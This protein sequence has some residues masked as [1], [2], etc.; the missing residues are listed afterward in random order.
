[1]KTGYRVVLACTVL[2]LL[3][4]ACRE[5]APLP[6]PESRPVKTMVIGG[7]TSGDYR[8]FPGVVDAMQK[9]ELSFRVEGKLKE[10]LVKE[11]DMVEKG[12]LLARLDPTDYQ[13][14]LN[15]RKASYE[16]AKAN[17][18][19][20][21]KLVEKGAISRVDHDKIRAEYATAKANLE[22]A[23][24]DL[25][26]TSLKATFPGYIAK[27]HVENFEEVRRKQAIFTLQDI[28]ELEI[29]VDVPENLM[30]Q[31]RRQVEPGKTSEPRRKMYAV[32][33][34]IKDVEFPL[35][36]KEISTTADVNTRTFEA[37]LKMKSPEN[38]NVLPGMTATVFAELFTSEMGKTVTVD[39]PVT[40]VVADADKAATVWVVDEDTMTVSS[41]PVKPGML[42][43]NSISVSGL[44]V[45]ERV[46]TAGAAFMREGMKVTLLQTGEQPDQRP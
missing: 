35:E 17:Y 6:P 39:L 30:I 10:I 33:D 12:Q 3:M 22:A 14:K 25:K 38:Y 24:Q 43:S 2:P 45:G 37:T 13:I 34:Q 31:L 7:V 21:K 5:E 44:E 41:K 11:G 27:R 18:E 20:A 36:L 42:S 15:D 9:A 29:R 4:T 32:F 1:M 19:R 28:S 26:Y 23:E 16:T 46:V 8:Q 40:A